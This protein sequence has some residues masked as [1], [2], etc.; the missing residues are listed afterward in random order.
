MGAHA[1]GVVQEAHRGI[2]QRKE[3]DFRAA[4]HSCG[5]G[6]SVGVPLQ[7]VS[8]LPHKVLIVLFLASRC[9]ILP[10]N[11]TPEGLFTP[12][13][14]RL[15]V[16]AAL[17]WLH[18]KGDKCFLLKSCEIPSKRQSNQSGALAASSQTMLFHNI[19]TSTTSTDSAPSCTWR[20]HPLVLRKYRKLKNA[21]LKGNYMHSGA[22]ERGLE[23]SVAHR[24]CGRTLK[25]Q[26][27]KCLKLWWRVRLK[28]EA[29]GLFHFCNT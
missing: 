22:I 27:D 7:T 1:A 14:L 24:C 10:S 2:V 16:E 26:T 12:I 17:P 18:R 13:H 5:P 15:E 11:S 20:G 23:R 25:E 4:G 3:Q 9:Q 29:P 21:A 28:Q 8:S 6:F 19:L